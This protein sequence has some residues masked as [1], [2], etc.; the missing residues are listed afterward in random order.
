M[1]ALVLR[2]FK[3]SAITTRWLGPDGRVTAAAQ[4]APP[5]PI[6]AVIGPPGPD[7]SRLTRPAGEALG[8]HRGVK[9][10]AD[11]KAVYVSPSDADVD[12]IVGLT[13]NA[14]A[15][16]ETV[17]I[18]AGG[19]VSESGWNWQPGAIYLAASGNLTQ[20][21]PTSGAIVRIGTALGPTAMFVNP[22]L[23]ARL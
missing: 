1:A 17:E 5:R 4:S 16:G 11:G 18:V 15:S 13:F 19:E 21:V 9:V 10:R 20:T 3:P 8:G 7:A 22:R 12:A 14:A 6:A 2:W 23:I